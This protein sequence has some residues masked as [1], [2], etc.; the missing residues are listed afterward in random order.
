MV[1]GGER[2]IWLLVVLPASIT[3]GAMQINYVL[4]RQA[5]SA[6]RNVALYV[7]SI[8][9]LALLAAVA[10]VAF[11]NWR[12]AGA[13]W[14]GETADVATR[15]RFISMLGALESVIFFLVTLAQ[16]LATIFFNPCQP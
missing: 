3:A 8:V 5:C 11:L 13:E 7:V 9:A 14:P 2:T 6:Q 4:V 16:G 12:S 10:L 15:T 1:L